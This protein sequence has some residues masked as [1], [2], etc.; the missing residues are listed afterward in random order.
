MQR[1]RR[2]AWQRNGWRTVKG[3]ICLQRAV[4]GPIVNYPRASS[5]TPNPRSPE[6]FWNP[7]QPAPEPMPWAGF[8]LRRRRPANLERPT[9]CRRPWAESA[10]VAGMLAGFV[11]AHFSPP[12][13]AR[14]PPCGRGQPARRGLQT[15]APSLSTVVRDADTRLPCSPRLPLPVRL[16]D[17][18][19]LAGRNH[20]NLSRDVRPPQC[21]AVKEPQC[22]HL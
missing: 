7:A 18:Q 4:E 10:V 14:P 16:L 20:W 2:A 3:A 1:P 17:D 13:A 15:C 6:G 11:W 12:T 8:S 5:Y 21:C 22:A 19:T 9:L